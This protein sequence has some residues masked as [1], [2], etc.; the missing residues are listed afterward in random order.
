MSETLLAFPPK[1]ER[2]ISE[3][4]TEENSREWL[5]RVNQLHL[6][7]MGET[8]EK[9]PF[10]YDHLDALAYLALRAPATYVQT[11]S[12]LSSLV[13]VLPGWKPKTLL[14]VGS[15]PGVGIWA[16]TNVF[17]NLQSVT[18]IDQD[19]NFLLLGR[20]IIAA[21]GLSIPTS[22]QQDKLLRGLKSSTETY[23]IVLIVNV[24]SELSAKQRDKVI[25]S[26]FKRCKGIM[27]IIEPGTPT[28]SAII[29][30]VAKNFSGNASLL[31]P[32][33]D[34]SYVS[35]DDYWLHFS[36]RFIRPEF[37]RRVR[38]HLRNSSRMAS[39]WEETKYSYVIIGGI[40]PKSSPWGRCA[41]QVRLHKGYL[42]VPVL[43]RDHILHLKILKRQKKQYTFAKKLRWGQLISNRE[44]ILDI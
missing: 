9:S 28:G 29:Q 19:K 42:E 2:A 35:D 6:R 40:L 30:K 31:A 7:Y 4:L 20:R 34:N 24:L 25:G 13:E 12:V 10:I 23:D 16:T 44:D 26:A 27:V 36:K 18:C 3:I 22:W 37:T 21:S 11:Q 15:G 39:D 8:Q 32:Y 5:Q 43:T 14:D 33:I 38:Q 41:G 17:P 1:I